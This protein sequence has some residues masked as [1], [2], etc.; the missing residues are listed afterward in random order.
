MAIL[1][2]RTTCRWH[3]PC[4]PGAAYRRY[5]DGG[6]GLRFPQCPA[7]ARLPPPHAGIRHLHRRQ[8]WVHQP[9]NGDPVETG[10]GN[11]AWHGKSI[12][13]QRAD[14]AKCKK[15]IGG[16]NR[17]RRCGRE[18]RA[19]IKLIVAV[20]EGDLNRFQRCNAILDHRI[21]ITLIPATRAVGSRET[22]GNEEDA[23]MA[24]ID[25]HLRQ[26][27]AG[28][29]IIHRHGSGKQCGRQVVEKHGRRQRGREGDTCA[30]IA[31]CQDQAGRPVVEKRGDRVRLACRVVVR[32]GDQHAMA[33]DQHAVL[34]AR[35]RRGEDG[36]GDA[37]DQHAN[38]W[39]LPEPAGRRIYRPVTELRRCAAD[40]ADH[41]VAH[42][43]VAIERPARGCKRTSG[44]YRHLLQCRH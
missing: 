5:R 22:S 28:T 43:A 7:A 23:L 1:H 21:A 20:D 16:D 36:I 10:H 6:R 40:P 3:A 25:Q 18:C 4:R 14:D 15:I 39:P 35:K 13:P 11:I 9:S 37:G 31:D 41:A 19:E 38:D 2:R 12:T 29:A 33:G 34:D 30:G 26:L 24:E 44:S 8:R 17:R 32:L 27:A 42:I